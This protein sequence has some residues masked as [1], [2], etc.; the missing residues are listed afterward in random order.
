MRR[1]LSRALKRKLIGIFLIGVSIWIMTHG[2]SSAIS[3]AD[4]DIGLGIMGA[5]A[6][7]LW[8]VFGDPKL[9]NKV[10]R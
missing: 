9:L 3:P 5:V 2:N 7:G 8:F 10:L 6:V 4:C 1:V